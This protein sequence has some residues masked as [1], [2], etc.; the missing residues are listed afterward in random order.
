M[1]NA[2]QAITIAEQAVNSTSTTPLERAKLLIAIAD[3]KLQ[4]EHNRHLEL[5]NFVAIASSPSAS[6]FRGN[7]VTEKIKALA[8]LN[9][10]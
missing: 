9:D 6:P 7:V 1:S 10:F 8:G 5:A 3:L 4:A 2:E